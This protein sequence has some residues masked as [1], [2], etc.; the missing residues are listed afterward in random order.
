ML[1]TVM[2]I[3]RSHPIW[4]AAGIGAIIGAVNA[5]SL[6]IGGLRH[7]AM[8][9]VLP[10]LFPSSAS[11]IQVGQM[12]TL[13]VTLLLLIEIAGNVLGFAL[14]F[15]W[16]LLLRMR[17][18]LNER[19]ARALRLYGMSAADGEDSGQPDPAARPAWR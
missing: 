6:E 16:L 14:L 15:G 19:K 10:F 8:T 18:A 1:K 7:R 13:Q 3:G 17:T 4:S 9:G 11:G 2:R 12:S 5:V